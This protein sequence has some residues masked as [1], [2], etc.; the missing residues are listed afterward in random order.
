MRVHAQDR[1]GGQ[2]FNLVLSNIRYQRMSVTRINNN[3]FT[4]NYEFI[5]PRFFRSWVPCYDKQLLL[6]HPSIM[7]CGIIRTEYSVAVMEKQG[8]K[9]QRQEAT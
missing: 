5:Y 1:A 4:C 2:F 6:I 7:A 3:S 8:G 9:P